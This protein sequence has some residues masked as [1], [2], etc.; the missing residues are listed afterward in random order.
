[1][2]AY[3]NEAKSVNKDSPINRNR[4]EKV[5]RRLVPVSLSWKQPNNFVAPPYLKAAGKDAMEIYRIFAT[6]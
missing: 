2:I 6:F 4:L 3:V 1:M 5:R